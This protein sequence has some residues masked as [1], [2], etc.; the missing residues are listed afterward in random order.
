M[1][2][3]KFSSFILRFGLSFVLLAWLFSKIDMAKIGAVVRGADFLWLLAGFAFFALDNV[4]L[5]VRWAVIMDALKLKVP[6]RQAGRSY[7]IGLFGNL[8]LPSAVGGDILKGYTLCK[9]SEE[10]TKVVASIILDRLCGF[11]G[12]ILMATIS[13][14]VGFRMIADPGLIAPIVILAVASSVVAVAL[15]HQGIYTWACGVANAF[16]RLKGRLIHM[17]NDI[18]LLRKSPSYGLA[19]VGIGLWTQVLFVLCYFFISKALGADIPLGY[20]F[21]FVPLIC[22][23]SSVPSLGGLGVREAGAVYLFSRIGVGSEMAV[24]IS[25]MTFVYMVIVGLIGGLVYV[26]TLYPRR[27]QH[28]SQASASGGTQS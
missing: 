25:L 21:V 4:F 18:T 7:M 12:V 27:I 2:L 19:A 23:A 1:P 24:S 20:F 28:P 5:M 9:H 16:P 11:A 13:F 6:L 10:R 3:K 14:V 15:F 26:I 8:F 17:H 22:I